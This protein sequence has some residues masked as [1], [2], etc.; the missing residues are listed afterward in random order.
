MD[1]D[2]KINFDRRDRHM[3]AV[4]AMVNTMVGDVD[5]RVMLLRAVSE[6][7]HAAANEALDGARAA[8]RSVYGDPVAAGDTDALDRVAERR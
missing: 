1:G 3:A 8:I 5:D 2:T 7:G 4:R 6:Y